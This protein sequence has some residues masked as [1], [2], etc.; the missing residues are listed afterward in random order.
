M[1]IALS[2]AAAALISAPALSATPLPL[3][4]PTLVVTVAVSPAVSR[5]LVARVLAEASEIWRAASFMLLWQVEPIPAHVNVASVPGEPAD[6]G[7][8]SEVRPPPAGLRVT[9]GG[10]V[11]IRGKNVHVMP[12]GW[13]M[14]RAGSPQQEIYLSHTNAVALL[15]VSAGVVGRVG[16]LTVAERDTLL[17]RAI[18]RA[19]AHEIGH[20]LLASKVHA[21]TG[22]MRAQRG[23]AELFGP[24]RKGFQ[25][26]ADQQRLIAARLLQATAPMAR[27]H[28]S[29]GR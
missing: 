25:V 3:T 29:A 15:A 11:G 9:V 12:L 1:P 16:T 6:A 27:A 21:S 14:F 23:A 22:L 26:Q 5:S 28:P 10:D 2:L 20:Y 7:R 17:G 24:S 18:G 19:L 8:L 13:I 4:P